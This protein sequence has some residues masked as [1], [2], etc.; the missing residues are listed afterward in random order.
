MS[1]PWKGAA[2]RATAQDFVAAAEELGCEVAA[3]EA[4]WQVE[5]SG[6]PFRSDG[7][8]ERRFEPHKLRK[9]QGNYKTSAA[10]SFAARE[11]KFDAAYARNAEDA[12]RASSWGGPQI[13]GFNA[14]AAGYPT[15][16][17]MVEAMAAS[18]SE[19]IR[20]FVRLIKAWGLASALRSHDWRAFAARYNGNAN[21]AEYSARIETAYQKLSG[22]ASPVVLRSGDKGV[23]VRRLQYALGIDVDGSFGPDTDKAVRDFQKRHGLTVDGVVG[24]RT[25]KALEGYSGVQPV[26]QPAAQDRIAQASEIVALA[27]T[28]AGAM[29]TVG[30]ALPESSVNLLII[31]AAVI[32]IGALALHAFRKLR[33][34]A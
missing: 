21:V 10:L 4:V 18:E 15:A 25:W 12:M 24:Q 33:G 5:A 22:R 32:G 28:A 9:P 19:Q 11:A 30:G 8:L 29:A 20:A 27:S 6:K 3:L 1:K 13:M 17:A 31:A 34:V 16:G 7:T 23:A 26:K 2:Q 14:N